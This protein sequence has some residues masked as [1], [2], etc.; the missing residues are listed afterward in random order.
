MHLTQKLCKMKACFTRIAQ[1]IASHQD[2][3]FFHYQLN[4]SSHRFSFTPSSR[5]LLLNYHF[6][7]HLMSIVKQTE[8]FRGRR[9]CLEALGGR[10]QGI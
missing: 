7:V 9:K 1:R 4:F 10:H 5:F 6:Y 3:F 8:W 2:L